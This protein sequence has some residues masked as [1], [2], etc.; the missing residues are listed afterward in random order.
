MT[1]NAAEDDFCISL[2]HFGCIS[3]FSHR[4]MLKVSEYVRLEGS[5]VKEWFQQA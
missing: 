3:A 5:L 1:T 2:Q 4:L